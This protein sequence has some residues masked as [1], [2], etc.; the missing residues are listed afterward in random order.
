M[1]LTANLIFLNNN[2]LP[3]NDW[4][5]P[6][7]V[8]NEQKEFSFTTDGGGDLLRLYNVALKIPGTYKHLIYGGPSLS[9]HS[10]QRPPF[11][12]QPHIFRTT[13]INAFLLTKATSN[14]VTISW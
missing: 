9:S 1:F 12:I 8:S 3:L 6:H 14:V 2:L 5:E 13:T 10:Q 4:S 7:K 11:L